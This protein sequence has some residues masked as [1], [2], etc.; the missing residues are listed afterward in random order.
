MHLEAVDVRDFLLETE[1]AILLVSLRESVISLPNIGSSL[2]ID[3]S[4]GR[5]CLALISAL[6]NARRDLC[7][8][9]SSL[10]LPNCNITCSACSIT[11]GLICVSVKVTNGLSIRV[12]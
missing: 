2:Q 1:P 5:I 6:I 3:S 9:K 4:D 12:P 7:L 10:N 8:R 11:P